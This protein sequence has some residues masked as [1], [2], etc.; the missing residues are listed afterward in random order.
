MLKKK[1]RGE[2]K[3]KARGRISWEEA[4]V[5]GPGE[6]R[7]G[8]ANGG[9]KD[10]CTGQVGLGII[11]ILLMPIQ[12]LYFGTNTKPILFLSPYFSTGKKG[13]ILNVSKCLN[14]NVVKP[15]QLQELCLN[16]MQCK[17]RKFD[18]NQELSDQRISKKDT[19]LIRHSMTA[20]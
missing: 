8:G 12:S 7:G 13:C 20:F 5:Y 10:V 11:I 17:D 6:R 16:K 2:K 19:N 4:R 3:D 1:E 18:T 14:L 9:K 15:K